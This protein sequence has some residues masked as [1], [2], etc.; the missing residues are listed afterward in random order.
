[1]Q[2]HKNDINSHKGMC[3]LIRHPLR[4]DQNNLFFFYET[5]KQSGK[6]KA[7]G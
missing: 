1:M 2:N 7:P 5:Y 4:V 3:K 6:N